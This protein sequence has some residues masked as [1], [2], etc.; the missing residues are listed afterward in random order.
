MEFS[1]GVEIRLSKTLSPSGFQA[2]DN[3][4]LVQVK[5]LKSA[6]A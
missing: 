1:D 2:G 3:C 4:D 5:S 6:W